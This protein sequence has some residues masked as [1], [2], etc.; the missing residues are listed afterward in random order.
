ME[1]VQQNEELLHKWDVILVEI[2]KKEWPNNWTS[3]VHDLVVAATV[4]E[5]RCINNIYILKIVIEDVFQFGSS[6][7]TSKFN[8]QIRQGLRK[9]IAEVYSVGPLSMA[10]AQLCTQVLV[11]T[12]VVSLVIDAVNIIRLTLAYLPDE[13]VFDYNLSSVLLQGVQQDALRLPCMLCLQ[14][15]LCHPHASKF[16]A[17]VTQSLTRFMQF[18][19]VG[20]WRGADAQGYID[21]D[22]EIEKSYKALPQD[23]KEFLLNLALFVSSVAAQHK[24]MLVAQVLPLYQQMCQLLLFLSRCPDREV[25]KV[26]MGFWKGWAQDIYN[27]YKKVGRWRGLGGRTAW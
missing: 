6:E 8:A 20:E 2:F 10:D 9:D 3:F 24:A 5:S 22:M 19:S 23:L 15:V 16:P 21:L 27:T 12:E 7:F 26:C 18:L 14:E 11:N 1:S 17:L 25:L 13:Q 4:S